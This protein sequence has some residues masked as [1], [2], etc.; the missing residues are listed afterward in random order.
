MNTKKMKKEEDKVKYGKTN[1][2][3]SILLVDFLQYVISTVI[4]AEPNSGKMI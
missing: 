3:V 2:R 1:I 4:L